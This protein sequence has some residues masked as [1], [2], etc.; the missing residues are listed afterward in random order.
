MD[1]KEFREALDLY[2][3]DELSADGLAS[4]SAHLDECGG[5]RRAADELWWL[6]GAVRDVV[7][8]HDPPPDVVRWANDRFGSARRPLRA[9]I[10]M[11]ALA[12]ALL[13]G[14]FVWSSDV[15]VRVAGALERAAFQ[16]DTPR[17]IVLDGE[18]VCR[19]CELEAL[20]GAKSMCHLKGHHGSLRTADGK[21]WTFMEGK[22]SAVLI[23][24]SSLLG[25]R[26]QVRG[27]LYRRAGCLEIE[28]YKFL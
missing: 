24:D 14:L 10:V 15:R 17:T 3:D 27:R 12:F 21:I 11:P 9:V 23:E 4:A 28:S 16:L 6:R 22:A 19:D 25:R 18:L 13:L 20:Y 1:C 7:R 8:R 5:C 26:V 2:V